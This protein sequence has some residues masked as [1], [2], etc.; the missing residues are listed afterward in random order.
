M[1]AR[2]KCYGESCN[3]L[4]TRRGCLV[5]AL[6]YHWRRPGWVFGNLRT[7]C[8]SKRVLGQQRSVAMVPFCLFNTPLPPSFPQSWPA[9]KSTHSLLIEATWQATQEDK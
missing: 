8:I 7:S 6:F 1:Y 9:P 2:T 5:V 3:F 4:D